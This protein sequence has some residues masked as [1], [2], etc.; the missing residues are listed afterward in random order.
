MAVSEATPAMARA[1][2]GGVRHD[3]R[4]DAAAD[5]PH[6]HQKRYTPTI[7]ARAT[8]DTAFEMAAMSVGY[9]SAVP[10][11]SSTAVTAATATTPPEAAST[12]SA[13]AW[14]SIPAT[15]SGLR[16]MRSDQWPVHI[17]PAPQTAG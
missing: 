10:T 15:M 2:A 5:V 13:V 9:T 8:G 4:D 6:V 1:V 3:A 11:P 14:M 16:P 17:C 12:T 7:G